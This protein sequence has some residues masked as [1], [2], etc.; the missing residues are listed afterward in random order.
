M[1]DSQIVEL[2]QEFKN[3]ESEFE[4]LRI[5]RDKIISNLI[6]LELKTLHIRKEEREQVFLDKNAAIQELI[7][8]ES[9]FQ[10]VEKL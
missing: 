2:K 10:K 3:R 4:K 5:A 7:D 6:E 9:I 1:S 8:R